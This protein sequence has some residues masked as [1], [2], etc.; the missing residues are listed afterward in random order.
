MVL[1]VGLDR[2]KGGICLIKDT[3]PYAQA[4]ADSFRLHIS[5]KS[6]K[7][8][9]MPHDTLHKVTLGESFLSCDRFGKISS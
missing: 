1:L 5:S 2:W 8:V 6:T 4:E 3:L 9:Q 7:G